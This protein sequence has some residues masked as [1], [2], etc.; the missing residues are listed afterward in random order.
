MMAGRGEDRA[1]RGETLKYL[2]YS[3]VATRPM[4]P[5]DLEAILYTARRRN[6]AAGITG[7]LLYR[8]D[9]FIQFLEGPPA[10]IDAL[11]AD[12]SADDRHSRLQVQ[13][14]EQT[15]E[16]SFGDWRM[17]FGMPK[18]TRPTGVDG[19]RDSFDDLTGGSSYEVVRRAAQDFS[20]WFKVR[21]RAISY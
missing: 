4:D 1:D 21:E 14:V 2:V 18:Q 19:V 8:N 15:T 11:M 10:E 5:S 12:I 9:T 16:R 3:S 6:L 17:G 13:V 20:I 7:L